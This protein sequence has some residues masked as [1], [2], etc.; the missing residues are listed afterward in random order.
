MN[1]LTRRGFALTGLAS[2]GMAAACGNGVGGNG[3]QIIDARVEETLDFLYSSYPNTIELGNNAAGILVMPV[4]TEAA[5]GFGGGYGQ[6]ALRV[7]GTSV[8]YYS[9][10]KGSFGFQIGASQH[11]HVLFFMTEGS[12]TEFRH[13]A[14]WAVGANVKY[15]VV[16]QGGAANAETT[17]V[18]APV[19][20]VIFG[21]AGIKL[22][23]DLEGTKYSRIIP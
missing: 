1:R 18:L 15:V 9:T 7:D 17:T 11:A 4:V 8:D 21:Q 6:G 16:D 23:I 22:G 13:S 3:A 14:G 2:A 10:T 20:A 12:L 19:V 5:F